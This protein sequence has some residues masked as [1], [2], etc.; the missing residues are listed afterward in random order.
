MS[1]EEWISVLEL[2]TMWQ[3]KDIR[4]RAIK[5]LEG[6]TNPMDPVDKIVIARKFDVSPWLVPSL[7]ELAKREKPLDLL[8]GYRLGLEWTLKVAELREYACKR[9]MCRCGDCQRHRL[10]KAGGMAAGTANIDDEIRRIIG[11]CKYV[12]AV[13]T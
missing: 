2:S 9:D 1:L 8:E 3:F 11:F 4:A 12:Q 10:L 7:S 6:L 5:A 13:I